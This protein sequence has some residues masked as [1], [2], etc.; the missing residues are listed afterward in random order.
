MAGRYIVD[1][2]DKE[3]ADAIPVFACLRQLSV[4]ISD[5]SCAKGGF[6]RHLCVVLS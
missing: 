5:R 2:A 6:A 4:P 1:E 3:A